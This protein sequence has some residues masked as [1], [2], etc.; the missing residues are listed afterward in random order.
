MRTSNMQA[1]NAFHVHCMPHMFTNQEC[2]D[3][4]G[5]FMCAA[6]SPAPYTPLVICDRNLHSSC[7]PA[8]STPLVMWF[9]HM[10]VRVVARR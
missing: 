1:F 6:L 4:A 3:H 5:L 8:P 2:T 7:D 9:V 10:C